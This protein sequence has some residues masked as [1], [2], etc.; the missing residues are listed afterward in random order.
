MGQNTVNIPDIF[1]AVHDFCSFTVQLGYVGD[2]FCAIF[3]AYSRARGA[4]SSKRLAIH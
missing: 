3:D 1:L 2:F 4:T